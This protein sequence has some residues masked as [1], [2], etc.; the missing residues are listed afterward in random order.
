MKL[1]GRSMND[2]I[3]KYISQIDEILE[4]ATFLD[5][6]KVS[7]ALDDLVKLTV[8]SDVPDAVTRNLIVKLQAMAG[9]FAIRAT[10]YS[11]MKK[12]RSG[13][14]EFNKKQLYYTLSDVFN[15]MVN[16]LKYAAKTGMMY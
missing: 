6:E 7:E 9:T 5:D 4:V 11:T 2:T 1:G 16:A 12:G 13:S 15:Q 8:K 10:Y 3:L 14:D